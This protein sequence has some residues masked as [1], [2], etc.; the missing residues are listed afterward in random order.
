V[1][2]TSNQ[3]RVFAIGD[4][5][6]HGLTS[7][8]TMMMARSS[9]V[10]ALEADPD[11]RLEPLF[12]AL[13]TSLRRNLERM[14]LRL[15]MTFVLVEDLGDGRYRAVG[16]H[17]PLLVWRERERRV[18][19]IDVHGVW[20]G[21]LDHVPEDQIAAQEIRLDPGDSVLLYTD[22]IVESMKADEM[23]GM[24]RLRA[25]Y[26]ASAAG[27]PDAAIAA[28]LEAAERF[29]GD[30]NDDITLLGLRYTG[31]RNESKTDVASPRSANPSF[32]A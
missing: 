12:V 7:G 26:A 24:A 28:I 22:G 15:Y 10:G 18:E 32:T 11:L 3:R 8:L 19:E 25:V 5:S 1:I 21:L 29:G 27:G 6:G 2:V 4:V 30:R 31:K 17:L 13:N 23:F 14:R 9:L 20:L 16:A